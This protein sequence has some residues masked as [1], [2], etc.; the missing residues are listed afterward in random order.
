MKKTIDTE[1]RDK[2]KRCNNQNLQYSCFTRKI[3]DLI[4]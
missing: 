2:S 1:I 3:K 4:Y